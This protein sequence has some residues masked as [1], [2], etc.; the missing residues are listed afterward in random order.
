MCIMKI[1]TDTGLIGECGRSMWDSLQAD[2]RRKQDMMSW[3]LAPIGQVAGPEVAG[4]MIDVKKSA[5]FLTHLTLAE[6]QGFKES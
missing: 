3:R 1:N 4:G 5:P 6:T 2:P